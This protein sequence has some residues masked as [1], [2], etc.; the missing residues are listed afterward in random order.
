MW[1]NWYAGPIEL[2]DWFFDVWFPMH[3]SF[4]ANRAWLESFVRSSPRNMCGDK[5]ITHFVVLETA[6]KTVS[7]TVWG[8]MHLHTRGTLYLCHAHAGRYHVHE[9]TR[10][11][12]CNP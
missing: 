8:R 7:V 10:S 2:D 4:G 12:R 1:Y 9:W 3:R 11:E 5:M 6:T